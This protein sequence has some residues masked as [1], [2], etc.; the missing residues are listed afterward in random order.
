M[1]DLKEEKLD[2]L[3]TEQAEIYLKGLQIAVEEGNISCSLLQ[4]KLQ[5]GYVLAA[6]ILAWLTERGFMKKD[7]KGEYLKTV[8]M[9]KEEFE[10]FCKNYKKS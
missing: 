3:M 6:N 9:T 4:R 5:I 7:L 2:P 1:K 8:V 10:F